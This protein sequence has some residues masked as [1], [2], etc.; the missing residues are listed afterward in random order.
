MSKHTILISPHLI[1]KAEVAGQAM[2]RNTV[3]QIEHWVKVGAGIEDNP[4]LPYDFINQIVISKAQ[5]KQK[6]IE[7]YQFD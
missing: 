5:K 4:E 3:Q 7:N 6:Q 2:N 1:K